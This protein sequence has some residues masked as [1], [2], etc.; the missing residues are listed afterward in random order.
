MSDSMQPQGLQ[1]SRL[2]HPWDSSGKNTGVG[3]HALLQGIFPTQVSCIAGKFFTPEL[4]G[5]PSKWQSQ[6][7]NPESGSKVITV[8]PLHC[9]LDLFISTLCLE[10]HH[11]TSGRSFS[12]GSFLIPHYCN[13]LN[14][15]LLWKSSVINTN[16][17]T[18]ISIC[19]SLSYNLLDTHCFTICHGFLWL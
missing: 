8:D 17:L 12:I 16:R 2:L 14:F 19:I 7:S 6:D 4:P 3:C 11:P 18:L 10:H 5:K 13:E 1:P 9:E 15:S